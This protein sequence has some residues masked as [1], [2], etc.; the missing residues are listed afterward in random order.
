MTF[1][2]AAGSLAM[3]VAAPAF[4]RRL[5]FRNVLIWVGLIAVLLLA[6]NAAFRPTWPTVVILAVLLVGG[7]FQS[8]QFMAYNTI[9]YA[10]VPKAQMSAATSFYTTFQQLTLSLGIAVAAAA[11]AGSVALR[12]G[13]GPGLPDFSVA[14]LTVAGIAALAPAVSTRLDRFAGAEMSG[15]RGAPSAAVRREGSE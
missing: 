5:G 11:L 6:L 3:R 15:Y 2:S 14:F 13:S 10:D 9:A 7:F 8:L 12:G 1:A 4:L